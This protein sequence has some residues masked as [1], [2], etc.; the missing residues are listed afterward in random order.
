MEIIT[1]KVKEI[2]LRLI[3]SKNGSIQ[4]SKKGRQDI[5]RRKR[6]HWASLR[7]SRPVWKGRNH[8]KKICT[9]YNPE[10]INTDTKHMY[11]KR[12]KEK[13]SRITYGGRNCERISI[14]W[15]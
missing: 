10:E 5:E 9:N 6:F 13:K 4:K 11:A 3:Q 7:R 1:R 12:K 8:S 15:L 14:N 2:F